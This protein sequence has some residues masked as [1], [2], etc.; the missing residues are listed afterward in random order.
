MKP[1]ML[2]VDPGVTD[3]YKKKKFMRCGGQYPVI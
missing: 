2:L 3:G 1:E